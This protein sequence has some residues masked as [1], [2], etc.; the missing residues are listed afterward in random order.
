MTF[1]P[2][3]NS[4]P[5]AKIIIVIIKLLAD[6]DAS[7]SRINTDVED[8]SG[9]EEKEISDLEEEDKNEAEVLEKYEKD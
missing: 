9:K 4:E 5:P 2:S 6:R 3:F 8:N 1:L 7:R